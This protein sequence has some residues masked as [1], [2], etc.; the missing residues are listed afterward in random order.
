MADV[1]VLLDSRRRAV[2]SRSQSSSERRRRCRIGQAAE[3]ALIGSAWTSRTRET[4]R[5]GDRGAAPLSKN[6]YKLPIFEALVRRAILA[7]GQV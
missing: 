6:A 4:P 1:A 7:A 2:P 5:G 3:A